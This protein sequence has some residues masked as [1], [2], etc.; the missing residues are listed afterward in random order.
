MICGHAHLGLEPRIPTLQAI[1]V[2]TGPWQLM[3]ITI[4]DILYFLF[5]KLIYK[6]GRQS[7]QVRISGG[8]IR[9]RLLI[10]GTPMV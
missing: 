3:A 10:R 6:N 8:A 7:M 9:H 4:F 1:Q 2:T 5:I